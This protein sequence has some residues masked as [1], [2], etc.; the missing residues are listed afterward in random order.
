MY[1][2]ANLLLICL[3][4][5]SQVFLNELVKMKALLVRAFIYKLCFNLFN[6]TLPKTLEYLLKLLKQYEEDVFEE[7]EE[8]KAWD[9]ILGR[10]S[11]RGS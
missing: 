3:I 4:D 11:S 8:E 6:S 1:A 5:L 9:D 10:N 7:A 2:Q